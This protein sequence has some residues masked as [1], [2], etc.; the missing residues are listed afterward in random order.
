MWPTHPTKRILKMKDWIRLLIVVVVAVAGLTIG[1]R[2][3]K[4]GAIGV[5]TD[6]I[7]V[8]DTIMVRVPVVSEVR[9]VGLQTYRIKLLG[10]IN[11]D[12]DTIIVTKTDSIEV[13][14]PI[15]QKVYKDTMYT[16]WVSGYDARLDSIKVYKNTRI[17]NTIVR[18][19]K[20]WSVGVQAG[21]GLTP[22]GIQPYI[23]VGV[24][25]NFR[26]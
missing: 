26:F 23:G 16:A 20:R 6:T 21:I 25:Y 13:A 11:S 17:V 12:Q 1:Y 10:R 7:F 18:E 5:D 14:L 24:Q 9:D 3:G 15:E 4:S 19:D 22:K 8:R 2:M